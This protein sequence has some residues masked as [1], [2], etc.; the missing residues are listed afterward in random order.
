[1]TASLPI[2]P[3]TAPARKRKTVSRQRNRAFDRLAA[4]FRD[5]RGADLSDRLTV[6]CLEELSELTRAKEACE[7]I[8]RAGE[9]DNAECDPDAKFGKQPAAVALRQVNVQVRQCLKTL[10]RRKAATAAT[11]PD[12]ADAAR[13]RF[14]VAKTQ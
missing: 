7:R 2:D 3:P 6:E 10:S 13:S 9:R 8:L 1:M 5:A 12:P 4:L 14:R 11:A